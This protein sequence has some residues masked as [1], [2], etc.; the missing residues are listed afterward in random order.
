MTVVYVGGMT[1]VGRADRRRIESAV[2][3][4]GGKVESITDYGGYQKLKSW[5]ELNYFAPRCYKVRR[6]DADGVT[7]TNAVIVGVFSG[8]EWGDSV[9]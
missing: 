1:L 7:R 3:Q 9:R 6:V 2:L 8:I 4:A 5:R